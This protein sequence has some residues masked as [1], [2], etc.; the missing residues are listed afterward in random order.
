MIP[1]GVLHVDGHQE[2]EAEERNDNQVDQADRDGR[3]RNRRPERPEVKQRKC[4]SRIDRLRDLGEI[5]RRSL[6]QSVGPRRAKGRGYC[7]LKVINGR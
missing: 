2:G 6:S 3:R 5:R 4:D 7:K 1:H